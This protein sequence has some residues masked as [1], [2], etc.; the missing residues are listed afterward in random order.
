MSYEYEG[1]H[2]AKLNCAVACGEVHVVAIDFLLISK[3][4]RFISKSSPIN[5]NINIKNMY[6]RLHKMYIFLMNAISI[7]IPIYCHPLL[8]IG[9]IILSLISSAA[10]DISSNIAEAAEL[11]VF[12][13]V[14]T[15]IITSA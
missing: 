14:T 4:K 7:S 10:L 6:S 15:T 11:V 13:M 1:F 2:V 8:K 5:I 9:Q 12:P 3:S